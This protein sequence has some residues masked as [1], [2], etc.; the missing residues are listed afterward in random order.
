MRK[1]RR[2]LLFLNGLTEFMKT[3]KRYRRRVR[4]DLAFCP[5]RDCKNSRKYPDAQIHQ[6]LLTKGFM[7]DDYTVWTKHGEIDGRERVH[8]GVIE[9][10]SDDEDDDYA[11]QLRNDDL[12]GTE[13]V[14]DHEAPNHE[15]PIHEAV[16]EDADVQADVRIDQML[17]DG[18][19]VYENDREYRKYLQMV[20]DSKTPLYPGCSEEHT[21]LGTNLAFME[22]KASSGMSDTCF[23]KMLQLVGSILPTGHKLAQSTYQA[24]RSMNPLGLKV[25]KIHACKNDCI[26]Y[27]KEHAEASE[28]PVC[29]H[30]RYKREGGPPNKVLWYFNIIPRMKRYFANKTH[31]E[32]MRWHAEERRTEDGKMRHPAD[33]CQW[34]N[35][36]RRFKRF[37]KEIRNLRL[38]L[39][40]DGMNPFGN[41]SSKHSTW[42]VLMCIYNLPS[43]MCMKRKYV[44]M[45]LLIPGPR[46][47]GNDIDVYLQP[48]MDDLVTL[49]KDGVE[50]WDAS[51]QE[52]FVLRA[53][54]LITINDYPALGNL[55]GKVI[56]GFN[57]CIK[58]LEATAGMY[59]NNSGKV[60]YT[61]NRRF[62]RRE[63][64]YRT[65][66]HKFD[67]TEE[68]A[69]Q[70][71]HRTGRE[72]YNLVKDIKCTFGKLVPAASTST[73]GPT[74]LF[75]KRSIFWDLPYWK[76]LDVRHA[77]DVMHVEK[78]VCESLIGVLLDIKGK[79]KDTLKA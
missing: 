20:E 42:P 50:V 19:R 36:D 49:W 70:P 9:G 2:E 35:I 71:E 33:G 39:S 76:D 10:V 56:K 4:E 47:P 8:E 68:H 29:H 11:P 38:G 31:A 23:T 12:N 75:K 13:A 3:V 44:M 37:A 45:P 53:L 48:L 17:R 22:L 74:P 63:H 51:K 72:V 54:L 62:L 30:S 79:A 58:C 60:V 7:P 73:S 16:A 69:L 18:E 14:A 52:Y 64:P 77:I 57:A 27:R 26:L 40:T 61:R 15:V 43:W 6:H 32:L 34:R 66:K 21:V 28:C 78:N 67:G 55:S 65:C 46:Q 25:E 41:M 5:C 59:L 1:D 24:K